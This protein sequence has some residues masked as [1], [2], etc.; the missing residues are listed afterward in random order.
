[1]LQG[2]LGVL[3]FYGRRCREAW[4]DGRIGGTTCHPFYG[5][6]SGLRPPFT[7]ICETSTLLFERNDGSVNGCQNFPT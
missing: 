3:L 6:S 1:M 2:K 4:K 7:L 5:N